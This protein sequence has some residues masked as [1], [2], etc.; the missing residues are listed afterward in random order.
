MRNIM[1]S[2]K[3]TAQAAYDS[4]ASVTCTCSQVDCSA[5]T[6]GRTSL[7]S[8]CI[9]I[10]ETTVIGMVMEPMI[11]TLYAFSA[12][13]VSSARVH[14]KLNSISYMLENGG[15][16]AIDQRCATAAVF[17]RNP[18]M[19]KIEAVLTYRSIPVT[20]YPMYS[21][22]APAYRTSAAYNILASP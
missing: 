18:A 6:S 10:T 5:G 17:A 12:I 15:R 11:L 8:N 4:I 20:P 19:V 3:L 2:A 14:T 1:A 7:G 13:S 21:V 22:A 16:P 9:R